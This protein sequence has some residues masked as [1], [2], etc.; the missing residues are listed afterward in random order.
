MWREGM[1]ETE[2]LV[3]YPQ[4]ATWDWAEK[5]PVLS[6]SIL[7]TLSAATPRKDPWRK[8][9]AWSL[10]SLPDPS[11]CPA[12]AVTSHHKLGGLKQQKRP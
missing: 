5:R 1:M 8:A 7:G 10:P 6:T 4:W 2:G 12:A 9:A 11:V 3:G